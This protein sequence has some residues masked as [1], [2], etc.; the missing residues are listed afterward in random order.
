[1]NFTT[2]NYQI[3]GTH[4]F[5]QKFLFNVTISQ[6]MLPYLQFGDYIYARLKSEI[7]LN[8]DYFMRRFQYKIIL[9]RWQTRWRSWRYFISLTRRSIFI[10]NIYF[11]AVVLIITATIITFSSF[12]SF[13]LLFVIIVIII[14][15]VLSPI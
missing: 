12:K 1:M 11:P 9:T 15:I 3:D 6:Y 10:C 4:L 8:K 7:M 13:F 14:T 5:C 2:I